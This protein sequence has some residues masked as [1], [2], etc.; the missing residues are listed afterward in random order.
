MS[1]G[2]NFNR[3]SLYSP[4]I[5]LSSWSKGASSVTKKYASQ[6]GLLCLSNAVCKVIKTA[7]KENHQK[8]LSADAGKK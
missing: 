4:R 7:Q 2:R 6:L 5:P 3:M 8:V 1:M